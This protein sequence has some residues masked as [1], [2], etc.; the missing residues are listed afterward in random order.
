MDQ[1][2]R[3]DLAFYASFTGL[4]PEWVGYGQSARGAGW[5]P[6]IVHGHLSGW[7]LIPS[8]TRTDQLTPVCRPDT[9]R[10]Q[11]F[12]TARAKRPLSRWIAPYRERCQPP[13]R[14]RSAGVQINPD[15]DCVPWTPWHN[16][17]LMLAQRRRRWANISP[18]LGQHVVFS[19]SA[20][21]P[22]TVTLAD[23]NPRHPC[24]PD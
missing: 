9:P 17:G 22:D 3:L 24:I 7:V 13:V 2:N 19:G 16:A 12:L 20:P 1:G 10:A 18:A 23:H 6:G 14:V 5:R 15:V 21:K 11:P 8:L 4:W